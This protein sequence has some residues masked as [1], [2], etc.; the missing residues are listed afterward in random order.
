MAVN[1]KMVV[2]FGGRQLEVVGC[3]GPLC[4]GSDM[5]SSSGLLN[6]S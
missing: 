1:M 4:S 3:D 5:A 6:S 2:R